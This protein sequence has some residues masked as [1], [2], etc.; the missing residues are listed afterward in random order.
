M[1]IITS[2]GDMAKKDRCRALGCSDFLA[3][4]IDGMLLK[5]AVRRL[6]H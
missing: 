1:I 5:E 2:E 6:L 3:K 4:P